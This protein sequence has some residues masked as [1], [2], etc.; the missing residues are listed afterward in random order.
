[1][2]SGTPTFV[3]VVVVVVS[4]TSPAP[5]PSL[6]NVS[7][8]QTVVPATVWHSGCNVVL[9]LAS[10]A[11]IDPIRI[12]LM[13]ANGIQLPPPWGHQLKPDSESVSERKFKV[14]LV[15]APE[16]VCEVCRT[17]LA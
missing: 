13:L 1:L 2:N 4:I 6:T 16:E 7:V 14:K 17:S 8:T 3:I 15:V 11:R 5:A 12:L 10:S 9:P